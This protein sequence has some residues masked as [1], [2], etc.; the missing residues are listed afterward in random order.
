MHNNLKTNQ[1]LVLVPPSAQ[2]THCSY[3]RDE[4]EFTKFGP[5]E[6]VRVFFLVFF[7][8]ILRREK[9]AL[10]FIIFSKKSGSV[11]LPESG[12][13]LF[14][15]SIWKSHLR[16]CLLFGVIGTSPLL[17]CVFSHVYV[18]SSVYFLWIARE[19]LFC[20]PESERLHR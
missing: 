17:L 9:L 19:V 5:I 11:M 15:V 20:F 1:I 3:R 8:L 10:L 18:C 6:K 2:R 4:R 12:E 13:S 16:Y 7:L 14:Q